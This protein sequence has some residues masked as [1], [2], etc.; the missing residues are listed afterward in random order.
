MPANNHIPHL[1]AVFGLPSPAPLSQ[2]NATGRIAVPLYLE[3]H[4][5]FPAQFPFV[6]VMDLGLTLEPAANWSVNRIASDGRKLLRCSFLSDASL[7]PGDRLLAA[8]LVLQVPPGGSGRAALNGASAPGLE[9][10]R[11][12]R[13]FTVTGA[14]NFPAE[15]GAATIAADTL[16]RGLA[17]GMAEARAPL[18]RSG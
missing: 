10:M 2:G 14:A 7:K 17:L 8:S 4:S 1:R 11:D 9:T 12:I 13:L 6:C 16:R 3:N 15:R 18:R 5:A